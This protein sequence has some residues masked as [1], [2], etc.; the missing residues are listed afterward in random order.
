MKHIAIVSFLSHLLLWGGISADV[1]STRKALTVPGM[2]EQ[3]PFVPHSLGKQIVLNVGIGTAVELV[4]WAAR[5]DSTP[6]WVA[7]T[8]RATVGGPRL[9]AGIWNTHARFEQERINRALCK[10][11]GC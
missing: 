10:E 2:V 11:S 4:G 3:N 5:H 1:I 7:P 9:A 8:L 6:R